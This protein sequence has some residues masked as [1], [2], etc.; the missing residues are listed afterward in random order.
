MAILRLRAGEVARLK[1][2]GADLEEITFRV[3]ASK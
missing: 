2:D 1:I 3:K